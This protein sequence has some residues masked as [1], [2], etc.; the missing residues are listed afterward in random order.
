MRS[1]VTGGGGGR[2]VEDDQE[3]KPRPL[4]KGERELA[5]PKGYAAGHDT[6]RY[7]A[8]HA[9]SRVEGPDPH[10]Q[11]GEEGQREDSQIEQR[12]AEEADADDTSGGPRTIMV[13]ASVR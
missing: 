8:E 2:D 4:H 5:K 1:A 13:V 10:R 9:G 7:A 11:A 6:H 12:P 3:P